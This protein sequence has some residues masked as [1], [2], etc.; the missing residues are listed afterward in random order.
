MSDR[1]MKVAAS[2]FLAIVLGLAEEE[3]I[4]FAEGAIAQEQTS[5]LE[6]SIEEGKRLLKEGSAKSL[7]QAIVKF[8]KAI[9]LSIN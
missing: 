7:R 4:G 6:Q 8:E 1:S 5:A 9:D 2:A 3:A